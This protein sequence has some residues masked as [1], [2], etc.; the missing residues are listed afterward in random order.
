MLGEG[1]KIPRLS[2]LRQCRVIGIHP[3]PDRWEHAL[4]GREL[5]ELEKSSVTQLFLSNVWI[6]P[7]ELGC[8]SLGKISGRL[9]ELTLSC[10]VLDPPAVLVLLQ[11][12]AN[13]TGLVRL[14]IDSL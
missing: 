9:T 7:G 3:Q 11:A 12:L 8:Q 13:N 4:R 6:S 14:T 2:R 5:E 10:T 1:L